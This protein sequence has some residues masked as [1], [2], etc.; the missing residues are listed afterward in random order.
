MDRWLAQIKEVLTQK[1]DISSLE[2]L[3][4]IHGDLNEKAIVVF[5]PKGDQRSVPR[6]ATALDFAYLIHTHI[7]NR[8]I[9][10]KV[11][12]RLVPLSYV[13]QSGDQVEIITAES[14]EPKREWLDFLH[15]RH[16]ISLVIDY[17]RGQADTLR[18]EGEQIL[19]EQMRRCN[20]H[21]SN[22]DMKQLLIALQL[23]SRDELCFRLALGLVKPEDIISSHDIVPAR[24]LL[25]GDDH[26][27]L[28]VKDPERLNRL[29]RQLS[30]LDGFKSVERTDF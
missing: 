14:G 5:T 13:L 28:Y 18:E 26:I 19:T 30:S 10:A 7:G 16:A 29:I 6:G 12:M 15:T 11:N 8:A 27:D 9:A 24:I 21:L 3:D 17:F 1:D 23:P 20:R 25:S 22:R 2:L 4:M